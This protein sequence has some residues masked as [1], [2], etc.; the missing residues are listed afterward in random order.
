MTDH[1]PGEDEDVGALAEEN[2]RLRADL[3]AAEAKTSEARKVRA[4]KIRRTLV[5]ILVILTSLSV[6]ASTVG[7][8]INRTVWSQ[9]RYLAL[10]TPLAR[11]TAVTDALAVK[12][13]DQ[14]FEA[15]NL[16]ERVGEVLANFPKVPS[17]AQFLVGPIESAMHDFVLGQVKSFLRSTTFY[18]LWV[19]L[20]TELHP[21]LVAL[22]QGDYSQL[23]NLS[24]SGGAVQ[25]NLIPV[26][27]QIIQRVVP[28]L[29]INVTLPDLPSDATVA[30]AIGL[31]SSHLGVSLPSDFGQITVMTQDQLHSYQQAAQSLRRLGYGLIL[32]TL[33][34]AGVTI[35]VSRTRRRTLVWL[36]LGAVVALLIGGAV[37]R[38]IEAQ[39]VNSLSGS[40]Q[41]AVRDIFEHV[42]SGLRRVG[43]LMVAVALVLAI[44]AH[45]LGR[46]PWFESLKGKLR[47]LRSGA[48]GQSELEVFAARNADRLRLG[49]IALAV[50]AFLVW[51]VSWASVIVIAIVV[52]LV[53]WG[54][55][56]AQRRVAGD[57]NLESPAPGGAAG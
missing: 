14:V 4:G 25:L 54:V 24:V 16:Q 53:L 10:V 17:Q 2:A 42:T 52:A 55:S 45:L 26:V 27:Y 32:L 22:L 23:P 39:V 5:V 33:V 30:S 11:D 28:S 13:T 31:V 29:G 35:A 21:K 18:N 48:A 34:L 44:V 9:D 8:W 20:N 49:I 50:I 19:Q 51:G 47:E 38:A 46:P 40:S 7:I 43:L 12:V 6:V 37:I 1:E 15:L 56:A 3:E 41:G 57:E 36:G